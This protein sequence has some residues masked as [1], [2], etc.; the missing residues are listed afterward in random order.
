LGAEVARDGLGEGDGGDV[1]D[2]GVGFATVLGLDGVDY[3][4]VPVAE[5]GKRSVSGERKGG[6]EERAY[7]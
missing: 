4:G 7:T 2:G 3:V 1:E 6:K 5:G